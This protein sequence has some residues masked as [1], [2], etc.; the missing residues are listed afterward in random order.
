MLEPA[1]IA[2]N[3]DIHAKYLELQRRI[4][5]KFP[6]TSRLTVKFAELTEKIN[7]TFPLDVTTGLVDAKQKEIIVEML[8]Q[9]EELLWAMGLSQGNA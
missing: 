3:L 2:L 8:E 1:Q 4:D 9:L 7:K 5:E 6:D